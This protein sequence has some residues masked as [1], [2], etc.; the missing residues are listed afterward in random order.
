MTYFCEEL[1]EPFL[2][3]LRGDGGPWPAQGSLAAD[4]WWEVA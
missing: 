1:N 2:L 4:Y 3:L